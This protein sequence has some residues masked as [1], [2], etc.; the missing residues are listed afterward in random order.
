MKGERNHQIIV[1][2][3][4]TNVFDFIISS[5]PFCVFSASSWQL[6]PWK[7]VSK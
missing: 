6:N 2:V 1:K 5:V 7:S 3:C 4:E